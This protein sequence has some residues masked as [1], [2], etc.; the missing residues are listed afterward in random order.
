MR[1]IEGLPMVGDGGFEYD[2]NH[3]QV[4]V[5]KLCRSAGKSYEVMRFHISSRN[6]N[7]CDPFF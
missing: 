3:S 5:F 2:L 1:I 6:I 4:A 7:H